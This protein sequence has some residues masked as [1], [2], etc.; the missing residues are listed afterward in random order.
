MSDGFEDR[1]LQMIHDNPHVTIN[2]S[3][4]GTRSTPA[5][6]PHLQLLKFDGQRQ[7]EFAPF[8]DSFHSLVHLRPGL[9]DYEKLIYLKSCLKEG[10]KAAQTLSGFSQQGSSYKPAVDRLKRTFGDKKLRMSQLIMSMV[11]LPTVAKMSQARGNVDMLWSK[12]RQFENLGI[13]LTGEES[14]TMILTLVQTKVPSDLLRQWNIWTLEQRR[15]AE[16]SEL[17]WEDSSPPLVCSYTAQEFLDFCDR[18][19]KAYDDSVSLNQVAATHLKVYEKTKEASDKKPPFGRKAQFQTSDPKKGEGK[20]EKKDKKKDTKKTTTLVVTDKTAKDSK[21][22][23]SGQKNVSD[24]KLYTEGCPFCGVSNHQPEK[25]SK[26]PGLTRLE[27]WKSVHHYSE[28]KDLCYACLR[29][30]HKSPDCDSVCGKDGCKKR[31]HAVLHY[32]RKN[33]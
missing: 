6:L 33:E 20:K 16:A 29:E 17:A 7:E 12:I 13:D 5:K 19:V 18:R 27:R 8:W 22:K 30:G 24:K 3:A 21:K 31:H 23:K 9:T 10:S 2:T 14:K 11:H 15:E 1:L 4:G 28:Q 26:L 32:D 25:C